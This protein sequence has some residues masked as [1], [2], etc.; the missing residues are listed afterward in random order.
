MRTDNQPITTRKALM[1]PTEMID[2]KALDFTIAD[3]QDE[4]RVDRFCQ[5]LV[6]YFHRHLLDTGEAARLEAGSLARGAD[7]FLRD[8]V[9]DSLRCNI[10]EISASQ[11]RGFAGNWYIQHT[12]EPNMKE[13]KT[14]LR[15]VTLFYRFC[16]AKGWMNRSVSNEIESICTE[17]DYFRYRIAS[18][19]DLSGDDYPAWCRAC[20]LT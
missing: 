20:P 8:F 18:Y 7:Y 2:F 4:I 12:L 15:G 11:L 9:I 17:S 10:F 16:A 1:L 14:I 13:L 19:H 6:S 3:L 5:Q